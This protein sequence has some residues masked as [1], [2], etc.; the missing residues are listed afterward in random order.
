MKIGNKNIS[1]GF[2]LFL[3][4]LLPFIACLI[5]WLLWSFI[6]PFV[7]FLFYPAVF[8]SAWVGGRIYAGLA[9][10]VVSSTLVW[11]FFIPPQ[12]TFEMKSTN[13][14]ISVW[15]FMA[16]GGLF[17]FTHDRLRKANVKTVEALDA[18]RAA[19]EQLQNANEKIN[20]LYQKTL[21]LDKLKTQFFSNVSHELRTPLTL[22][23][24]PLNRSLSE[25]GLPGSLRSNLEVIKRNA[26]LLYHHVSDLLDISK[27][28]AGRM[29]LRYTRLDLAQLVRVIASHF[30]SAAADRGIRY[31]VSTPVHLAVE[32]DGE[33]IQR[34]LLNLLSNAFKFVPDGGLIGV[35]LTTQDGR[36]VIG[37]IDN[38]PGVPGPLR[39][40]IFERFRQ[41]EGHAARTHGGTGLGL[42]IVREFI[43]LLGGDAVCGEAPEGGAVFTVTM[44]LS[45]PQGTVIEEEAARI[46]TVLDTGIWREPESGMASN[47]P[48]KEHS[49][50]Q[51]LSLI[52]VVEDNKDM[53]AYLGDILKPH[54]RIVSAFDGEDGLEKAMKVKPD[55]IITDMMMPKMSGDQMVAELRK[56]AEMADTPIVML[57]AKAD[58]GLRVELLQHGVQDYLQKP[59]L[60]DELLARIGGLLAERRRSFEQLRESE[61]KFRALF[62]N[63]LNSLVHCRLIFREGIA[64]DYEYIDVNPAFE[65]MTG[66]KGVKGR[67]VSDV[68]PGYCVD[69]S[70]LLN[71][72]GKV[73]MTG[74]PVH[75]EH[76]LASTGS[77]FRFAIYSPAKNEV[78]IIGENITERKLAE[79]GVL[80]LNAE[81]EHRVE[82]RTAG[83]LAANHELDAFAYAVSHDL[84]APLRAMSGFSQAL[85]EDFSDGLQAEARVYLDQITLASRRM[86]E[87][88]DGLLVLSRS[89]RCQLRKDR[90][91]L[92]G[93]AERF[94]HELTIEDPARQVHW[95][96]EPNLIAQGDKTM[97]EVVMRNLLHNA[98]KY[99]SRREE[100]AAIRFFSPKDGVQHC[101]CVADNGAGFNMAHASKLFQPFQRLHRQE[102][103]PGIGIGLATV[104]RIIHRHGG[105]IVAEGQQDQGATFC[106]SLPRHHTNGKGES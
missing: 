67:K 41:V 70:E 100:A 38:G 50:R 47:L 3:A 22:I 20:G 35:T 86:G 34:I 83:L 72:F 28:E 4:L 79:K 33:K 64:V 76:Y 31:A 91:D 25:P 95:E 48:M 1:D 65:K 49:E 74:T 94:L 87:L 6:K 104:Q 58:D 19:N 46:D 12:L 32:S 88:I 54:Y 62:D 24:G 81:L 40:A 78:A 69:N 57:T 26:Q 8:F 82:E 92:S 85:I 23:L 39:E 66:L 7:W 103:F 68:L 101:F 30:E 77:W 11:Y 97:M 53:N 73:A 15:I 9:S 13:N 45:A 21:E 17:S 55:L 16:M 59:F 56:H 90:V 99:S 43:E 106:F 63:M 29:E 84:R 44:P 2:G 102:E 60:D 36:A 37:I 98:W 5:Q 89:T 10:S 27:I 61:A 105:R 51:S 14:L 71:I 42:S 93:M 75:W 80:R 52:L 18:A 96:I